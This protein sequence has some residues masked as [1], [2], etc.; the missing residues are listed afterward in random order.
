M[1]HSA[2]SIIVVEYLRDCKSIYEPALAHESVDTGV[3][4][5]EEKTEVENLVRLSL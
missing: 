2:E 5:E 3:L 1:M 4:F